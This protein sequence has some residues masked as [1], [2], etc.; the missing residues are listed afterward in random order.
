MSSLKGYVS[1][2]RPSSFCS[3][4]TEHINWHGRLHSLK[5]I[6]RNDTLNPQTTTAIHIIKGHFLGALTSNSEQKEVYL[7]KRIVKKRK[8]KLKIKF[9]KEKRK[10]SNIIMTISFRNS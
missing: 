8:K 10:K 3:L 5:K 4:E 2:F 6:R 1:T 7:E 9:K